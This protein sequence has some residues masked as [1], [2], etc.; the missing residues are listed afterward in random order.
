MRCGG[1]RRGVNTEVSTTQLLEM[2]LFNNFIG[3]V[4]L[5]DLNVFGRRFTWYHP[6]GRS[7]SRI[8]KVLISEEWY[9]CWGDNYLWVLPRDVSDHCPL[10]LKKGG[11]DWGPKPF[12]FNNFWLENKDFKGVVD[13]A[14]RSQNVSGWMG[15]VLKEKLKGL[16][17][18]L[19]EWNKVEY[20]GMEARVEKLVVETQGLDEKGEEG[21]L[22]EGEVLD[23]KQKF[24][25]LWRVLKAKD[26]LIVQRSRSKWI[27]EGDANT[28]F[29]HNCLKLRSS[30][31]AIKALK[32]GDRW[33]LRFLCWK[34]SRWLEIVMGTKAR[35]RMDLIMLL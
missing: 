14:W 35:V 18:T 26:A 28:S 20:G 2:S 27:K 11:W 15:F 16:K 29:F 31:N 22:S 25:E 5:E 12:R 34:L 30:K 19:K 8:D 4:E 1:G 21:V 13:D 17:A 6:N 33:L 7:M 9:Q 32:E 23:R 10:V 3:E 24:E